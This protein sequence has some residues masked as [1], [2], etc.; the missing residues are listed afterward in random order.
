M[1]EEEAE[2]FNREADQ[3]AITWIR[4]A[5]NQVTGGN[6]TFADDDLKVLQFLAASAVK[7]GLHRDLLHPSIVTKLDRRNEFLASLSNGASA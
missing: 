3:A 2:A 7:A 5:A 4:D 1:T 6:F